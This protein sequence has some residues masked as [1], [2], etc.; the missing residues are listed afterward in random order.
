MTRHLVSAG[1]NPLAPT[2]YSAGAVISSVADLLPALDELEARIAR[3]ERPR[4]P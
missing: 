4:A 1:P 2:S 3:G